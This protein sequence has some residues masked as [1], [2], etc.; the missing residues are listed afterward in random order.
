MDSPLQEL[1]GL[2][3]AMLSQLPGLVE[4]RARQLEAAG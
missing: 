2:L 3:N 4:A 1:N